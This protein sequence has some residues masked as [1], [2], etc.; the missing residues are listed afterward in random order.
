MQDQF[1]MKLRSEFEV[2][3]G[4]LLNRNSIPC[5]DVCLGKLLQEKQRLAT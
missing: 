5:L 4:G 1:L 2:V 3:V